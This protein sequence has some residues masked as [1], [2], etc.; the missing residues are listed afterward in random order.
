MSHYQ[1]S[2]VL[3]GAPLP[4]FPRRKISKL[5]RQNLCGK[6]DAPSR[7][8]EGRGGL[9]HVAS[10]RLPSPLIEPDLRISGIRL[11]DWLHLKA[12]GVVQDAR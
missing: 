6:K 7:V 4:I 5:L 2:L 9:G 8:E 10:L 3:V 12:H 11:S 1:R